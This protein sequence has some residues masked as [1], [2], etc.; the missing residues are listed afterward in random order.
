RYAN[1]E[2]NI[3]IQNWQDIE[4]FGWSNLLLG[5][6]FS[7]GISQNFRY[8]SLLDVVDERKIKMYPHARKLFDRDRIDTVNFEE[9]LRVI[10]HAYLVNFWNTDAIETLYYN[11][12]KSLI[13][14]VNI[15]HVDYDDVPVQAIESALAGYDSIFTTNYDLIPYWSIMSSDFVGYCDYFWSG[16][17]SFDA[18]DTNIFGG[19]APIYYLHGALHLRTNMSG[20]TQ[21]V[22]ATGE[23]SIKQI[24]GESTL[25]SIP[26]FISEGKSQMKLRRIRENDYLSFCYNSLI[27]LDGSLLV[28][29]HGLDKEYDEHILSAIK[30]S[31]ITRLAVS[32]F[33]GMR[34]EDKV[35]FASNIIAY[36]ADSKIEV[37][38]F[39]SDTHPLSLSEG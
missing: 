13:E 22:R 20:V 36:F 12:R 24:I 37:V 35:A 19:K 21:K 9:V 17:T 18:S 8:D 14:A 32:V 30:A 3:V 5:N 4:T 15:A 34:P 28:F 31:S 29:G 27:K 11:V 23:T 33:T 26:L 2:V 39:N 1:K 6:G 10:Y 25:R 7:I 38:F 16:G